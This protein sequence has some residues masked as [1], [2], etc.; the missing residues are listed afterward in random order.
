MKIIVYLLVLVG[1]VFCR[2]QAVDV[3]HSE[4]KGTLSFALWDRFYFSN[5]IIMEVQPMIMRGLEGP[6]YY[7]EWYFAFL[8]T[9]SVV[10]YQNDSPVDIDPWYDDTIYYPDEGEEIPFLNISAAVPQSGNWEP[11][12]FPSHYAIDS[13]LL[14]DTLQYPKCIVDRTVSGHFICHIWTSTLGRIVETTY[15]KNYDDMIYVQRKDG[16]SAIRL[17]LNIVNANHE[18]EDGIHDFSETYEFEWE[19]DSAG[20]GYFSGKTTGIT[21][22]KEMLY[23]NTPGQI[24]LHA[25]NGQL[26]HTLENIKEV[27][28]LVPT[29]PKGIYIVHAPNS[30]RKL[31]IP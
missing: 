15:P 17:K 30:V 8:D 3:S 10:T 11:A 19:R 1:A 14:F 26:L 22:S 5:G 16:S 23:A 28:N 25:L 4:S 24:N 13:F 21:H 9:V 18:D 12:T 6:M 31:R 7:A 20:T 29:L 2:E 27:D